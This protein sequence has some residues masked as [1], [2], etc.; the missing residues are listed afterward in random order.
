M[1]G[2][3]VNK[4]A[5]HPLTPGLLLALAP[6]LSCPLCGEPLQRDPFWSSPHWL[7]PNTHSYS[8]VRVLLAELHE[9]GHWPPPTTSAC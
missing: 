9:R 6:R 7:C 5:R 4:L 2:P 8:N 1:E 3:G